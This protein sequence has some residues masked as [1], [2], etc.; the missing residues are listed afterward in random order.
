MVH[1]HLTRE[2]ARCYL[3][4]AS[5]KGWL[6]ATAQPEF[7]QEEVMG[8]DKER[9]LLK[10]VNSDKAWVKKVNKMSDLQ[11]MAVYK[12]LKAQNKI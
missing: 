9:E 8:A 11:V 4:Q 6:Q 1:H 3:Q 12:R 7:S 5:Q 10:K 2:E